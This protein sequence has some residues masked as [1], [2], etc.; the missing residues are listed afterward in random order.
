MV[1]GQGLSI[2]HE[3]NKDSVGFDRLSDYLRKECGINLALTEKNKA[4]LANRLNKMITAFGMRSYSELHSTLVSG[5]SDVKEVFINAITTNTTQFFREKK[6]FDLLTESARGI[7][8]HRENRASREIRVWCAAC[9]S[10]EEAY[11][12]AMCLRSVI[13]EGNELRI[14]ILATDID[15]EILRRAVRG[16]Y[17]VDAIRQIPE[18]FKTQFFER[19]MGS[20]AGLV[21]VRKHIRDMITFAPFNLVTP[22]YGFQHKFD[23]VFCRNV[24]IYF[25]RNEI[26]KTVRKL[27]ASLKNGGLLFVGHSESFVTDH[28]GLKQLA[29]AVYRRCNECRRGE[30]A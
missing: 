18:V 23:F 20:S 30:A 7:F 24:M 14:R 21:R 13:P 4:L 17:A 11:S 15:T 3:L 6:H 5:R 27:E 10:G 25:D 28:P 8:D 12:I 19:G 9:S 16:V 22:I 2:G 29:P 1:A 26:P